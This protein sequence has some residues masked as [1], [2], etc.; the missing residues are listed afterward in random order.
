MVCVWECGLNQGFS[1][2]SM[3]MAPQTA[4]ASGR[5]PLLQN[6]QQCYKIFKATTCLFSF[7]L[8][9]DIQQFVHCSEQ[10]HYRLICC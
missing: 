3:L 4:L 8:L 6:N 7:L 10:E 9:F 1:N 5:G 2:F